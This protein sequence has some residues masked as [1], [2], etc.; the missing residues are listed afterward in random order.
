MVVGKTEG[1][2][3]SFTSAGHEPVLPHW[4]R[5]APDLSSKRPLLGI[6]AR[7]PELTQLTIAEGG[8]YVH[9]RM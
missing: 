7:P 2:H 6:R 9:R 1:H 8:L 4:A 5:Q 3:V